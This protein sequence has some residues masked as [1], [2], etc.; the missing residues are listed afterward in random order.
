MT[1]REPTIN[2]R[3]TMQR[4]WTSVASILAVLFAALLTPYR[5]VH[6]AAPGTEHGHP[7]DAARLHGHFTPHSEVPG[8]HD[9]DRDAQ[10]DSR[11]WSVQG[12]AFQSWSPPDAP[13]PVLL[14][15]RIEQ[16]IDE[17]SW[18]AV[19]LTEPVAH[20]P[21]CGTEPPHRGPPFFPPVIA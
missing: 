8:D 13:G 2:D 5:H 16:D 1:H 4:R 12:F 14:I 11:F 17:P 21:P 20:G 15:E 19:N 6:Q 7:D 9:A 18:I 10:T 3:L